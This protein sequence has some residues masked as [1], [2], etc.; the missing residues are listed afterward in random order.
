MRLASHRAAPVAFP[1]RAPVLARAVALVTL[2]SS[3]LPGSSVRAS[4]RSLQQG[5]PP[6]ADTI[7]LTGEVAADGTL[8]SRVERRLRGSVL[9]AERAL[10]ARPGREALARLVKATAGAMGLAGSMREVRVELPDGDADALGVSFRTTIPGWLPPG[11]GKAAA[12]G[13]VPLP[14]PR[15]P[16]PGGGEGEE[17]A[18]PGGFR[19]YARAELAFPAGTDLVPPIPGEGES[20][21]GSY[22]SVAS[23]AGPALTLEQEVVLEPRRGGQELAKARAA[24]LARVRRDLR[25]AISMTQREPLYASVDPEDSDALASA[26]RAARADGLTGRAIELLR[27]AVELRPEHP[28]AWSWLGNAYLEAGRPRAAERALRRQLELDPELGHAMAS[29]GVA[30]DR[31]GRLE[32][33]E[34]M[35]RRQL[36]SRPRDP[37]AS[38]GLASL[39]VERGRIGEARPYLENTVGLESDDERLL[40]TLGWTRLYAGEP[41]RALPPLRKVV[42]ADSSLA[43]ARV[44]LGSALRR[45]GRGEEALTHLR[46]AVRLAPDRPEYRVS[47][48][49][50][51]W[52]GDRDREA[53]EMLAEGMS[54]A[55]G[56]PPAALCQAYGHTLTR[57][58]RGEEA[59]PCGADD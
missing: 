25:T 3:V 4:T 13:R 6:A 20:E 22:R 35:Y 38:V 59:P 39:L 1:A 36:E 53:L 17:P 45:T 44:H 28:R 43:A 26:G 57:L 47:L 58:G 8:T 31:Q 49:R 34:A 10:R 7:L 24:F 56:E 52:E 55:E 27:R 23:V 51:L 50:V 46:A 41:E 30:L 37:Y 5:P 2:L 19:F 15:L 42:E 16:T 14:A 12:D 40:L 9:P 29:L 18:Y 33:A 32:E 54:Q 21:V 11:E 48:A